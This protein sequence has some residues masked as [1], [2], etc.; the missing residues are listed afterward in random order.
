MLLLCAGNDNLHLLTSN[1]RQRLRVDLADF[2]INT[3]YAEYDYFLVRSESAK[4]TLA[5]LGI[6]NGTA[7][8]YSVETCTTIGLLY[9]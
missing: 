9:G 7:G 1:A 5:S 4:F 6:Y 2:L 8:Q 3:R